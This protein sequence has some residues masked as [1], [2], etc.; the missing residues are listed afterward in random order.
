MRSTMLTGGI[1]KPW[2]Q[3]KDTRLAV[4]YW[5]VYFITFIGIGLGGLRCY[6]TYRDTLRLGKLCLVMEDNFDTFDTDFTW[7]HEVDMSGFGYV[8]S[9][10]LCSQGRC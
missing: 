7:F 8:V 5:L 4:A 6:F 1:Q 2:L 9:L 10:F 3:E